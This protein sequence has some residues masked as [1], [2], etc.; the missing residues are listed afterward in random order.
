VNVNFDSGNKKAGA[1]FEAEGL[2]EEEVEFKG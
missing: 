2:F 1:I